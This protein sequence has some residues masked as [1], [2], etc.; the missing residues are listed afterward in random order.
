MCLEALRLEALRLEAVKSRALPGVPK[1]QW[2]RPMRS[3]PWSVHELLGH[4]RVAIARGAAGAGRPCSGQSRDHFG[5]LLPARRSV[6]PADQCRPHRTGPARPCLGPRG[7]ARHGCA[8][9]AKDW[10]CSGPVPVDT[11]GLA[12]LCGCAPRDPGNRRFGAHPLRRLIACSGSCYSAS[13]MAPAVGSTRGLWPGTV[14]QRPQSEGRVG[15]SHPGA[16]VPD[17][18]PPH[19]ATDCHACGRRRAGVVAVLD[20]CGRRRTHGNRHT[21]IP[22]WDE[23]PGGSRAGHLGGSNSDGELS[24]HVSAVPQ[25]SLR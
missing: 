12:V 21:S 3:E 7:R 1:A 6:Q 13:W 23:S 16:A 10:S 8:A 17:L 2:D 9:L 20:N 18:Q 5:G 25:L 11:N 22:A 19:R 4:L 14:V 24:P 15:L